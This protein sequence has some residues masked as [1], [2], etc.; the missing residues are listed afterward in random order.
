PPVLHTACVVGVPHLPLRVAAQIN[1]RIAVVIDH[2]PVNVELEITI[3]LCRRQM[4]TLPVGYDFLFGGVTSP[5]LVARSVPLRLLLLVFFW[6]ELGFLD[7]VIVWL[8]ATPSAE[9][10]S[11]E[12]AGESLRRLLLLWCG[13]DAGTQRDGNGAGGDLGESGHLVLIGTRIVAYLIFGRYSAFSHQ[14]SVTNR[15]R[16]AGFRT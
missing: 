5:M 14:L 3:V 6:S 15:R 4:W 11:I 13:N 8:P 2:Q 1:S 7:R 16:A 12:Q 10:L 9:I